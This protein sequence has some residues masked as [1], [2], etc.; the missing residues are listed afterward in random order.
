M[1]DKTAFKILSLLL[2]FVSQ[3][4]LAYEL[5]IGGSS[6]IYPIIEKMKHAYLLDKHSTHII[7][8]HERSSSAEGLKALLENEV[9]I[10]KVSRHVNESEITRFTSRGLNIYPIHVGYDAISVIVHPSKKKILKSLSKE[11]LQK[12]FLSQKIKNWSELD[13][14]LSGKIHVYLGGASGSGTTERFINW[15]GDGKKGLIKSFV[16][17]TGRV[18]LAVSAVEKDINGITISPLGQAQDVYRVP[19]KI[20]NKLISGTKE[21]IRLGRYPLSRDL[22]LIGKYPFKEEV[23]SFLAFCLSEQGQKIINDIGFISVF[24]GVQR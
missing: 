17:L 8:T 24:D 9:D 10:A 7:V 6:A 13:S 22:F 5:K 20:K 11:Q 14:R 1:V 16:R 3:N 4:S 18:D 15:L 19:I 23:A 12:I 2:I 21:N